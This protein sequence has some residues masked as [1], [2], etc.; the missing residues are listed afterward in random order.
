MPLGGLGGDCPYCEGKG[1]YP[2]DRIVALG[3]FRDPL[4]HL[5]YSVKYRGQWT[6][7]ERLADRLLEHESAKG[8]LSDVDCVVPVPL[9]A[10]R[11]IGR[12]F[13]QAEVIARR[14][15]KR[16]GLR[17]ARAAIRL[18]NTD[19][20]IHLHSRAKREENLK[21]AF[22]L[23]KERPIRGRHVVIV[24]DVTTT[25]ATLRSLARTLQYA[26]PA[27]LSAAVLAV[28]DPL[29]QDFQVI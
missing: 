25:G 27:S 5:I 14:L 10:V 1:L 24:D 19:S 6:L 16:C 3:M 29:G 4:R 21:D 28:A 12:G 18:R 2:F 23:V 17:F 22:G 11:H 26:E 8:L 20:Q 9:H 7:A 15:A 13:N